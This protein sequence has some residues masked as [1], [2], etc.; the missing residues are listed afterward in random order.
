MTTPLRNSLE[1]WARQRPEDA[2]I[3]E[4]GVV[5]TYG[6]WNSRA[7]AL[8]EGLAKHGVVA[9]DVIV[10]RLQIRKEWPIVASAAAKLGCSILGLNWR[11]TPAETHYVLS[12]SKASV[13]I[14]DDPDPAA[15]APAFEGLRIKLAVS[16]DVPANGFTA[17]SELFAPAAPTRF[18]QGEAPLIIYTSGTTGLPK[19]VPMS[20]ARGGDPTQLMEYLRSVGESRPQPPGE[21]VLV[22]MPMHHGAGPALVRQSLSRGNLMIFQRRFD[23][24]AALELIQRHRISYWTAVPTMY[25]R[26]AGLPAETLARYDVSSIKTLGVGAAPVPPD[27]KTW[28]VGYFG[29]CLHEGYGATEVGMI[30]ALTPEMHR[31][32]PGSSG[33]PHT[34]VHIRIRD[35]EGRDL[36]VGE[37]G[38]IWIKTPVTISGYLNADT[39]GSD[40]LDAEGFFRI[41]D[42]GRLDEDGYLF[43]TDRVKDM[44]ISGGVNIY[45]AEIEAALLKHPAVQDAAVIGIPDDEFGEQ[46][47]AFV[48]LKPGRAA[49]PEEIIASCAAHLASYKRPRSL[50]VM[51]ELPR[52]TMGKLLKRELRE[53]YWAGRERKV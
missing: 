21:V 22:T 16:V 39:L 43:I 38:E 48:E 20:N 33:L 29:D 41:G 52:N 24:E 11:L 5:L 15:L 45:P 36:P 34:H 49:E 19:G 42:V 28:I 17:L 40:T 37:T 26:I 35:D 7:D 47:K 30:T 9:G 3:I 4:G 12:N 8:A 14:C 10:T 46:V 32:K 13:V 6:A 44:I 1:Y 31:L 18:S 25:K 23:P 27:L 51:T 53:P 2:A 50:D